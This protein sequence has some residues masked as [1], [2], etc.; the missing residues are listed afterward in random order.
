MAYTVLAN[1][2]AGNQPLSIIDANFAQ[3]APLASPALTGVPTAPTAAGGTNN[4]QIATTAFVQSAIGGTPTSWVPSDQSGAGLS[5]TNVST[6]WANT[7]PYNT[8]YGTLTFPVTGSGS[9]V[10]LS[11]PFA[12]PAQSYAAVPG[13]LVATGGAIGTNAV[14]KAIQN[15]NPG[16][17]LIVNDFINS[18]APLT[19]ANF[20]AATIWFQIFVPSS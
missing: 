13:I 19:N 9:S 4:N 16:K 12:V 11:L 20:T 5:F 15:T 2:A 18:G 14:V 3:A 10:V 8:A 6:N 7:G 1:L 17:M